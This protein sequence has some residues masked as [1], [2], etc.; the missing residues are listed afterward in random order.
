MKDFN[1]FEGV[2]KVARMST[3]IN[4]ATLAQHISGDEHS[5][6]WN[7]LK[8]IS[9]RAAIKSQKLNAKLNSIYFPS[10]SDASLTKW[11]LGRS[12][13][14]RVSVCQVLAMCRME[15]FCCCVDLKV[16]CYLCSFYSL[17]SENTF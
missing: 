8:N 5:I 16:G 6:E 3:L 13:R 15:K 7:N 12:P 17:V 9:Q 14:S 11:Q 1:E 2:F 4:N 10:R